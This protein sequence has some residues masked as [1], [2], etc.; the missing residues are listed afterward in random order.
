MKNTITDSVPPRG[1]F[2]GDGNYGDILTVAGS[3]IVNNDT[4]IAVL[5]PI[6][7]ACL[8]NH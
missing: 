5:S 4:S 1:Y 7:N 8:R 6:T 3:A 2:F